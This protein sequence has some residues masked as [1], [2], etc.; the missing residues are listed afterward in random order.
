M[1]ASNIDAEYNQIIMKKSPFFAK[2]A[3]R[4]RTCDLQDGNR[5]LYPLHYAIRCLR[6]AKIAKFIPKLR[7]F[8][9]HCKILQISPNIDCQKLIAIGKT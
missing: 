3:A 5:T 8:A 6:V 4:D 7:F 9:N 1:A 2:G